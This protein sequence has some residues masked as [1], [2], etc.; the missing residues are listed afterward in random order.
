MIFIISYPLLLFLYLLNMNSK[1]SYAF[2]FAMV[3]PT[4]F[5]FTKKFLK[6]YQRHNK[7]SIQ[8]QIEIQDLFEKIQNNKILNYKSL[9]LIDGKIIIQT[10]PTLWSVG[11]VIK[12]KK[13]NHT[14]FIESQYPSYMEYLIPDTG[15]HIQNVKKIKNLFFNH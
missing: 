14:F 4:F 9:Q 2:A 8:S 13:V 6:R 1:L 10:Q 7:I 3:T 15:I 12:I 11:E 5:S